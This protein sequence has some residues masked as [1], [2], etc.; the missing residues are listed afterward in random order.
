MKDWYDTGPYVPDPMTPKQREY[1]EITLRFQQDKVLDLLS[2]E[3]RVAV[4]LMG[5]EEWLGVLTKWGA[6]D[7]I[8]AIKRA[9]TAERVRSRSARTARRAAK[10]EAS[11]AHRKPAAVPVRRKWWATDA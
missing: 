2:D 4:E 8:S 7:L 10:R 1:L 3:E 5:A 6:S 9:E 11:P